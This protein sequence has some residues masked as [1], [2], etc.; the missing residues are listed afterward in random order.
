MRSTAATSSTISALAERNFDLL[1]LDIMMPEMNGY[2]VLDVLSADGRTHDL[3]VLV[4]S[5][6]SEIDAVAR[7]IE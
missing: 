6:L 2:E 4:I 5:A 1:L 3:P 7:C